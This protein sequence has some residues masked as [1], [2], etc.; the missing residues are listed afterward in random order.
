MFKAYEEAGI[1]VQ[2]VKA[3]PGSAEVTLNAL[4]AGE[5]EVDLDTETGLGEFGGSGSQVRWK[6]L[7]F[8]KLQMKISCHLKTLKSTNKCIVVIV[9][10][11]GSYSLT[12]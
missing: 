11:V 7:V 12:K 9:I 3:L 4:N 8:S 1:Q 5:S 2:S 10:W 6:W